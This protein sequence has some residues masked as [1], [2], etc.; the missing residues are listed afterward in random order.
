MQQLLLYNRKLR[1]VIEGRPAR[2]INQMKIIMLGAPGAG[3][4]T[5]AKKIAKVYDTSPPEIFSVQTLRVAQS[6]A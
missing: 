2:R 3:K 5:Q 1:P 6:W 4:G